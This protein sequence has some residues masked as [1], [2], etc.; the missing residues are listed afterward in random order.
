MKKLSCFLFILVANFVQANPPADYERIDAHAR[1]TP[2]KY[3]NSIQELANYLAKP[4]Q[5]NFETVRSFYVWMAE[6]IEY[7]VDLF[8]RYQS[9]VSLNVAPQAVLDRKRAVCQGYAELFIALCEEVGIDSRLVPGYSKGFGNQNRTDF[10]LAD[11][12]WNAVQIDQKWYLLDVTWGAGGLNEKMQYQAKFTEK[13]FLAAPDKFVTDHMPLQPMWQLLACPVS[14]SAFAA[15]DEA[16]A[17]EVASNDNCLNFDE[18]I[19]WFDAM[20]RAEYDLKIAEDAYL[21]NPDNHLIMAKGYSDYAH[22]I[23][24]NIK[25]EMSS[26]QEIEEAMQAQENALEYLL[27]A[28]RLL[29]KV[30]QGGEAYEQLVNQNIKNSEQNLKAMKAVLNG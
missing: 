2:P 8:R 19:A 15:G 29:K 25:R 11:H 5:N 30:K 14:I 12:A 1:A 18:K 9:G 17:R 23:M 7:D 27:K 24:S 22:H 10:S 4:A 28:Q 20:P 16:I 13:Y 6:N 21:F 3:T 26:R